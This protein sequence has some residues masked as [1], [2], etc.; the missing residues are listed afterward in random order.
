MVKTTNTIE[1]RSQELLIRN[2]SRW[3]DRLNQGKPVGLGLAALHFNLNK[4]YQI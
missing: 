3:L 1:F 2:E 4:N